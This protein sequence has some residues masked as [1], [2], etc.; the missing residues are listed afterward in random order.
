MN[1]SFSPL[2]YIKASSHVTLP[3]VLH[4]RLILHQAAPNCC[5]SLSSQ[6]WHWASYLKK[7]KIF[8][9]IQCSLLICFWQTLKEYYRE[10]K[11]KI[12]IY[13]QNIDSSLTTS[14]IISTSSHSILISDFVKNYCPNYL[15]MFA[16]WPLRL[17]AQHNTSNIFFKRR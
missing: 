10:K 15:C 14:S 3:I 9:L 4:F 2:S 6:R 16:F 7:K 17:L 13:V 11:K 12:K 1:E 5:P 8:K